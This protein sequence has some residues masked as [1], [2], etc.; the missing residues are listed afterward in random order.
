VC[1]SFYET[2]YVGYIGGKF[3]DFGYDVAVDSA[4]N[5]YVTGYT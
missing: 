4:G 2:Q 3:D 5:A 1:L